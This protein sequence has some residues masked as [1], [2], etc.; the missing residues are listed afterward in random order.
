[1]AN[2]EDTVP[3]ITGGHCLI[4]G[5]F[6]DVVI[7]HRLHSGNCIRHHCP[8]C[9][10]CQ[11]STALLADEMILAINQ[12]ISLLQEQLNIMQE[13]KR[14]NCLCMW[15]AVDWDDNGVVLNYRCRRCKRSAT[16]DEYESWIEQRSARRGHYYS[17]PQYRGAGDDGSDDAEL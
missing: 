3:I 1:M 10:R 16:V 14:Q 4:R 11:T 15:E 9:P 7:C 5:R 13:R 12:Q 6:S 17:D 2:H 8:G